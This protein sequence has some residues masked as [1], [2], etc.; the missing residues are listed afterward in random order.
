MPPIETVED[1]VRTAEIFLG[2][3]YSF[4]RLQVA[5]K[6]ESGWHLE[7]DVGVLVGRIVKITLD[8]GTGAVTSYE[9]VEG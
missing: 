9:V 7:F 1:A 2:R 8:S 6:E 3:Y 5:R 4:R